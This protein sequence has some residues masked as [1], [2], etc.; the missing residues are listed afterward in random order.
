MEADAEFL[1]NEERRRT[2]RELAETKAVLES[3]LQQTPIPMIVVSTPDEVLRVV[4]PAA[5][6]FLGIEDEPDPVGRS[7][8]E[9]PITWTNLS[10]DGRPVPPEATLPPRAIRGETL[11][12]AE[13]TVVRKDGSRHTSL[14]SAGP[15]FGPDGNQIAAQISFPDITARR[16][17]EAA[18]KVRK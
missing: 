16:E 8:A 6:E 2:E 13:G 15:I 14:V 4:N 3:T 5:R 17:A 12:D 10:P 1:R 9:V 18:L 7:L 11:R